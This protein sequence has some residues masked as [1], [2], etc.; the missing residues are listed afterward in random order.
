MVDK[1]PNAVIWKKQNPETQRKTEEKN[2]L[3]SLNSHNV[4]RDVQ[5]KKGEKLVCDWVAPLAHIFFLY[6]C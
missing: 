6:R 1:A 3:V 5:E 2:E 4:V